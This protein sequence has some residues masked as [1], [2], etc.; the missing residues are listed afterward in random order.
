MVNLERLPYMT[1]LHSWH[2]LTVSSLHCK[3]HF[4]SC[5]STSWTDIH[6]L[7][8]SSFKLSLFSRLQLFGTALISSHTQI[9]YATIMIVDCLWS[10]ENMII[11]RVIQSLDFLHAFYNLRSLLSY[12]VMHSSTAVT[13]CPYQGLVYMTVLLQSS[14]CCHLFIFSIRFA[15]MNA[16]E[17]HHGCHSHLV[18]VHYLSSVIHLL[19]TASFIKTMIMPFDLLKIILL[20]FAAI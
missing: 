13:S 19:K 9:C 11:W 2:F 1:M 8:P 3:Q 17:N 14:S 15:S 4:F 18:M 12:L 20:S 7:V 5:Q 10:L 16:N 6:G